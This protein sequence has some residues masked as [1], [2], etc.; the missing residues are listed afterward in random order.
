MHSLFYLKHKHVHIVSSDKRQCH[1]GY[2]CSSCMVKTEHLAFTCKMFPFYNLCLQY[3]H[4][5]TK[6][7]Q[8][9]FFVI[10]Q[11]CYVTSKNCKYH[12][13]ENQWHCVFEKTCQSAFIIYI[14]RIFLIT[15][16][17]R[18]HFMILFCI[19]LNDFL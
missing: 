11:S 1:T 7:A 13:Y 16:I 6:W 3:V 5:P 15:K 9:G 8:W 2:I 18:Y 17:I 4:V 12:G 14:P 10:N 19:A